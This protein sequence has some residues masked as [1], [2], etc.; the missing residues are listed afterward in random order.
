MSAQRVSGLP[1]LGVA[2][3]SD[4][5]TRKASKPNTDLCDES[6]G[7]DG[8]LSVVVRLTDQR[9][10]ARH[11]PPTV[12]EA[13]EVDARMLPDFDRSALCHVSRST[14]LGSTHPGTQEKPE[15]VASGG[16]QPCYGEKIP[17]RPL[18][19]AKREHVEDRRERRGSTQDEQH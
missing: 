11:R 16:Q 18:A 9:S 10:A 4:C 2:P 6:D 3:Q 13:P 15:D 7:V 19:C 5:D 8:N 17:V 14:L 1:A 12:A